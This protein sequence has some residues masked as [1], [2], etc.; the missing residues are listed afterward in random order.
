MGAKSALTALK[1]TQPII[2]V[3]ANDAQVFREVPP[4]VRLCPSCGGRSFKL[5]QPDPS[6][7]VACHECHSLTYRS[8]QEHC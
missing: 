5:Y 6:S 7:S 8:T 2:Q 3:T 1:I 4:L